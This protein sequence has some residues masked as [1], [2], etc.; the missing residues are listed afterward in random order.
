MTRR[1]LESENPIDAETL[2]NDP[3]LTA[4]AAIEKCETAFK[5]LKKMVN[6]DLKRKRLAALL[7]ALL[8][9]INKNYTKY[10]ELLKLLVQVQ[11]EY[12]KTLA[13]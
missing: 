11:R 10:S 1:S 7:A 5:K 13:S 12:D 6:G 4:V 3:N 9:L 8:Y 2:L